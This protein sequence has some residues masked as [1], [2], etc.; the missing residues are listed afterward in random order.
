MYQELAS[1]LL[2]SDLDEDEGDNIYNWS[3]TS[4]RFTAAEEG[5]YLILADYWD[6]ELPTI[7]R[8]PAYKLVEV[9]E[10]EDT[11]K[12]VS[13]WLKNNMVSIIL[14]GVAGVL[15]IAVVVLLFVKPSN[16]TLEDVDKK[17][18]SKK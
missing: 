15:A 9:S 2:Y 10:E 6:A 3:A 5:L 7:D 18:K 12:G 14:F 1:L 17:A 4:R 8:V 16:E 13:E 11:I